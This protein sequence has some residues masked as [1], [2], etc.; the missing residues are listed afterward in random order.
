MKMFSLAAACVAG[1]SAAMVE[2]LPY[3][4]G[5]AEAAYHVPSDKALTLAVVV[6]E[7]GKEEI[8]K[9][10]TAV[11]TPGDVMY[12]QFLTQQQID[13]ITRPLESDM[14]AVTSWL[15]ANGVSYAVRGISRVD[16]RT[17]VGQ[18]S[19]LFSTSF[20]VA[21]NYATEQKLVRAGTYTIPSDIEESVATIFGFHGLPLPPRKGL[22]A[23]SYAPQNN[24]ANVT[25]AV[26]QKTY[27]V[28]GIKPAGTT[29][30]KQAVA[31]FQGQFMSSPD[32]AEMFKAYVTDY[33]VGVD[34]V[35]YKWVG[36]HIEREGNIEALLDIQYIMGVSVGIKTEFYEFPGAD[37]GSDLDMWTGNLSMPDAPFVHS[38]SYGWQGNLS[39]IHINPKDVDAVDAN[40][41]KLAAKGI[42]IMI[43]S[44]DSGS[45]YSTAD[46]CETEQGAKGVGIVGTAMRQ[47][48][49]EEVGQC[50]EEAK[51]LNASGWTFVP[52]S[53]GALR[54][55]SEG[56]DSFEFKN[57]VYSVGADKGGFKNREIFTLNGKITK[58]GGEVKCVN[59][60]GTYP[61]TSLTFGPQTKPGLPIFRSVTG[62]FG[63][64]DISGQAVFE[65][66]HPGQPVACVV[67]EW[68]AEGG[69]SIWEQGPNPPLPPPPGKCVL[70]KTVDSKPSAN[71][72][73]FSG[74][75]TKQK[76]ALWPSWPASSPWITAVGAT[77]FIDQKAGNAEMASDQF[78]SG[79]GFSTQF[80]Q[81]NAQ[82][83][84]AA[85]AKYLSSVDQSTLPPAESFPAKGRGTPDVAVL[86]E[87]YQ[88]FVNGHPTSVG[89]T[90]ASTPAFAG[91]MSMLNDARLQA[92]KPVMGFLNPFL[93][94]NADAFTDITAGSNKVGRGGESLPYGW[95]CSAGWD[96]AT[97]LG[98]PVFSKLLKAAMA[99]DNN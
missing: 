26:L 5:W 46:Q 83:Q 84:A 56:G 76:V 10:A 23:S 98:T 53:K 4:N 39:Q 89:G 81:T 33:K 36:G 91:M 96:P 34:D 93:Y 15:D 86:G 73:T 52:T 51:Q 37:F 75:A 94:K 19:D 48:N 35:V 65:H 11:S 20:H 87:G 49:V 61:D 71:S 17:T 7:Q 69:E 1:A 21:K 38:V 70:Y 45:G 92:G 47:M 25:P 22:I 99:G 60:N 54:R 64:K 66:P 79:G 67:I 74:F 88:V 43:S 42:S 72:T 85:T 18:A 16:V 78:G 50:C 3:E 90:S 57:V 80:D 31:E 6:K 68:H 77:R 14:S 32:L 82:Y 95:N 63:G 40:F 97:G 8:N 27:D 55:L 2:Q 9:V 30:N 28:T 12:G 29:V 13:D 24:P 59:A 41:A 58:E 62:T 44:G